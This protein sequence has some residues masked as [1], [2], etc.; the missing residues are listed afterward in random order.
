MVVKM[1]KSIVAALCMLALAACGQKK[2]TAGGKTLLQEKDFV[3]EIDGK[4]TALYT[5]T[6]AEGAAMQVTSYGARIVSLWVKDAEGGYKDVVLGYPTI[7]DYLSGDKFA[8]PIV[9]RY[10]NRIAKG[11]FTLDGKQYGLTI[12]DGENHLHGGSAG[13]WSKV[14]DTQGVQA[15][16]CGEQSITFSLL[17]PDGDQGYPGNVD[18]NVQYILTDDNSVVIKYTATTDAPTVINPTSHCYFNLHG[19]T[20]LSTDSHLLQINAHEFTLTDPALIPTGETASVEDTPMDFSAPT[21]IGE[22]INAD[23]EPLAYG[24]G[25]DHNFILDSTASVAAVVY[26][27]QTGIKMSIITDQ[28]ALQFYSGNFMDGTSTGKYGNKYNY[29]SGI[30][31]EAQNYPDAPNH[32]AFPSAVLRP[33]QTYSQTTVYKFE[34][35]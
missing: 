35:E 8:G 2:D 23:Y 5:L 21:F 20:D 16:G 17:S 7:S 11:K 19:T 34:V 28:P 3:T 12:N 32:D 10:G 18:V 1:K 25:Y 27:P 9:G 15:T 30:A 13:W 33:G 29:R 14:W 26:E 22:R 24:K 4:Q 31:L 6:N